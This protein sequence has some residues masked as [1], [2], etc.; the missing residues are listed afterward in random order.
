MTANG[1]SPRSRS[2]YYQI[3][4]EIEEELIQLRLEH[5]T[6]FRPGLLLNRN[7]DFRISEFLA[8]FIPFTAK[9]KTSELATTMI[10]YG[11]NFLE[12]RSGVRIRRRELMPFV[13]LNNHEIIY[14]KEYLEFC[15]AEYPSKSKI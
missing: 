5:L 4:G 10:R 7:S 14:I 1:A 15:E 2:V 12:E 3:K 6:I 11:I 8:K 9:I 13:E